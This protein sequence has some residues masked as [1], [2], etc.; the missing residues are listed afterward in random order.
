MLLSV[1][2]QLFFHAGKNKYRQFYAQGIGWLILTD[3]E[4]KRAKKRK[5][6]EKK[7]ELDMRPGK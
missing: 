6:P 1:S 3:K 2:L 5:E 7:K 4:L